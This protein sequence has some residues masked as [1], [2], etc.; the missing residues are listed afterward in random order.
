MLLFVVQ[1]A[2]ASCVHVVG[3][4]SGADMDQIRQWSSLAPIYAHGFDNFE[5]G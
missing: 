2:M 4:H 1:L 3:T 5:K